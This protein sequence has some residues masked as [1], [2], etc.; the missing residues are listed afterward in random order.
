VRILHV[1]PGMGPGGMETMVIQ[2]AADAVARGD[3]V[4]IASARGDWVGKVTDAGARHCPLPV[5]GRRAAAVPAAGAATAILA[6]CVNAWRP[7]IIHSHNVRATALARLASATAARRPQHA[8]PVLVPTLH[9]IAPQDY[10]AASLILRRAARRV[11]ACAPAVARSLSAAGFDPGRIDVIANGAQLAPASPERVARMRASLGLQSAYLIVGIGRLVPQK[12]WPVLI[13]AAVSLRGSAVLVAGDGPLRA[14][15]SDLAAQAGGIVRFP[16][17]IDDIPA[18]VGLADCVVS[19]SSWEGLPL[20]VLEALSV[21][22]PV[23]ATAVGGIVDVVPA[24]AVLLV[25]PGDPAAVAA[26]ISRVLTDSELAA[27]LRANAL[28]AAPGWG[29]AAMLGH[30]HRAYLA[31]LAQAPRWA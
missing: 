30:Y 3:Q 13:A 20:A 10:P 6:R 15:L 1:L 29:T 23:V 26:A 22:V 16:G 2:L 14:Q 18:L 21:G 28:A 12:D 25:P 8:G 4:V 27:R 11:I 5:T 7:D 17:T 9:G 24:N 31:A 19:T